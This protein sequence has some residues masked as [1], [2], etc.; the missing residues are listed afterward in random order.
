[1]DNTG[2]A[3][4]ADFGLAAL[5]PEPGSAGSIKDGH[6]V[7]WA[8]PEI[9]DK[10]GPVTKESDVYS[11]AMVV[12]EA[13]TGKAPFDGTAPTT[14]AVG[15]LSGKRPARPTDES[16]T[17]ALW[18]MVKRC[19]NDDP[20]SRP[21]I[22]EVVDCLEALRRDIVDANVNQAPDE[23]TWE[24]I[25]RREL[26][27]GPPPSRRSRWGGSVSYIFGQFSKLRRF[28]PV[29]RPT[30]DTEPGGDSTEPRE[31][32]KSEDEQPQ[33]S[34]PSDDNAPLIQSQVGNHAVPSEHSSAEGKGH[35]AHSGCM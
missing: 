18:E 23:A 17:D 1:M 9:L 4:L 32:E 30:S 11:F 8:A 16:L 22:S 13:F 12:I 2:R 31:G 35:G 28:I 24:S 25:R 29:L 14:V 26:S 6:A 19:W 5:V 20:K 21:G 15:I 33:S 27:P 3:C 7:R 10:D 34:T